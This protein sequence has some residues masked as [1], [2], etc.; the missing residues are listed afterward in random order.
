MHYFPMELS[1]L[2]LFFVLLLSLL[3]LIEVGVLGYAYQKMGV[4]RRYAYSILLL[5]L[6]GSYVNVPV[7]QLPPEVIHSAGRVVFYGVPYIVPMLTDVP[8]TMIAVNLGG[9]LI[10]TLLAIYL[11]VK[12]RRF[13]DSLAAIAI[14]TVAVHLMAHPVRGVGIAVPFSI[15]PAV[16]TV[17]ALLLDRDRAP[18]LAFIAGTLGTLIGADLLNIGRIQGLGAPVAS[19]G[20]AGTFDGIFTTGMLAVLLAAIMAGKRTRSRKLPV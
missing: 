20:G 17:T 10:P 5:C 1:F 4:D 6:I 12:N 8:G 2:F 7:Y 3:I 16:A 14:V 11:I 18:A 13:G 15:P 9:A 19:I